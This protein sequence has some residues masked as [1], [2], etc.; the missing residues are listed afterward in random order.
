MTTFDK[1]VS[2]RDYESAADALLKALGL[3]LD[4]R[5]ILWCNYSIFSI[6]EEELVQ[7]I[8]RDSRKLGTELSMSRRQIWYVGLPRFKLTRRGTPC[9]NCLIDLH[10]VCSNGVRCW[11]GKIMPKVD[12]FSVPLCLMTPLADALAKGGEPEIESVAR[13]VERGSGYITYGLASQEWRIPT[14]FLGFLWAMTEVKEGLEGL[15]DPYDCGLMARFAEES[16]SPKT[17]NATDDGDYQTL[18]SCLRDTMGYPKARAEDAAKYTMGNFADRDLE[19]KIKRALNYLSAE[20][21]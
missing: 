18:V 14:A 1:S 12:S 20:H 11:F 2:I 13:I 4:A 7:A 8:G 3:S 5:K 10:Y 9:L 6:P 17:P 19:E 21:H 15:L 16:P